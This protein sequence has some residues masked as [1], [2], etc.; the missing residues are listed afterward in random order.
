MVILR[1]LFLQPAYPLNLADLPLELSG[2][3]YEFALDSH[4]CIRT[5]FS[6]HFLGRTSYDTKQTSC[7]IPRTEFHEFHGGPPSFKLCI[8]VLLFLQ[9]LFYHTLDVENIFPEVST[10][11]NRNILNFPHYIIGIIIELRCEGLLN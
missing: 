2:K 5:D 7:L 6:G 3:A 9:I 4:R 10:W 8:L 1:H 11:L